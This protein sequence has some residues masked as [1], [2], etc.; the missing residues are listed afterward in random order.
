[1]SDLTVDDAG[2]HH[3]NMVRGVVSGLQEAFQQY[4]AQ[5]DTPTNMQEPLDHM[6]NAVQNTQ[7]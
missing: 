7:K 3:A 5:T 1:M 4:Q 2:M 6:A